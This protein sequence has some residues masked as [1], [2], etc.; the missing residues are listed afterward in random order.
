MRYTT[1]FYL[2]MDGGGLLLVSVCLGCGAV[3]VSQ[4]QDLHDRTIHHYAD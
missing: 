4:Y 1:E 3:V 2:K